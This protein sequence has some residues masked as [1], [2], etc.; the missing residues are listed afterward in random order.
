MDMEMQKRFSCI[1]CH[2]EC[3]V[4][5][6]KVNLGHLTTY[7]HKGFSHKGSDIDQNTFSLDYFD[8][9]TTILLTTNYF[10]NYYTVKKY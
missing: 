9:S 10:G 8:G 4:M 6:G 3:E 5:P 1:L 7:Q 2:N